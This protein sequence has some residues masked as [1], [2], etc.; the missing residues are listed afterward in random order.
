MKYNIQLHALF[1]SAFS[2]VRKLC[3]LS[4]AVPDIK[5]KS[6]LKKQKVDGQGI[7]R[8]RNDIVAKCRDFNNA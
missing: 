8:T 7:E 2:C 1:L 3:F 5:L 4:L 6:K